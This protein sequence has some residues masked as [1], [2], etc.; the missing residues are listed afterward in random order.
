MLILKAEQ[1]KPIV[2][3]VRVQQ[4]TSGRTWIFDFVDPVHRFAQSIIMPRDADPQRMEMCYEEL[5]S[6][7]QEK[8]KTDEW[9]AGLA[10]FLPL[11]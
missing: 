10:P 8:I 4:T 6:R 2:R 7:W 3:L 11:V 1:R 5:W 9:R